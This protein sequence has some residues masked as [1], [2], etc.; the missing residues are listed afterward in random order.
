MNKI[1]HTTA[2][3]IGLA[4]AGAA[5]IVSAQQAAPPPAP[6][7]ID[8]D[9]IQVK[10][11][12]LGNQTYMLMGQGG[13]ITVAVGSDSII[14]VDG[15]F[16]PL[17]DK[18]KAAIKAIS[19]LPVKYMLNTHF[20]GDH[21]GGNENF[22]KD[23]VIIV[24]HDNIR[25]R[26][27]A[28]TV[29][30]MTGAKA[31]PRP[32]EALPKQTYYGGSFALEA[33]G[34]KAQ[35]THVANAHTDGDTW[36][37]FADANVLATGD[38][39]NN[40]RRYQNIDYANGGDVRGMIRALDAYLKVANDNTKIVPGHGDLATKADLVVFREMLVTSHDRIK[41]LFDEGK[42]EAEV[43]AL[44]PLADLDATWGNPAALAVGHTR[45]V[46]NSFG[47]L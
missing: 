4:F 30:M 15:Q 11:I 32:P 37:Y 35:L 24:A 44:K 17:S 22:A 45:N 19:P 33:G 26:L 10:T 20:H 25:V 40:L 42:T 8:W 14:M 21:T 28:G 1:G 38:T 6:P 43:V 5:G 34:R 23:G 7:L 36:A 39:F 3:I 46:Y 2:L 29:S 12:D 13:N 9:K 16:A 18:I 27:A 31:P 47:R 41:K